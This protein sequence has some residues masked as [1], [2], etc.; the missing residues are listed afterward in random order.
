MIREFWVG[1]SDKQKLSERRMKY[2]RRTMVQTETPR[3]EEAR[4]GTETTRADAVLETLLKGERWVGKMNP[5]EVAKITS[6]RDPR[7]CRTTTSPRPPLGT[8][9]VAQS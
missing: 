1:S 8:V 3:A 5:S 7:I 9:A 4:K 6:R 2:R